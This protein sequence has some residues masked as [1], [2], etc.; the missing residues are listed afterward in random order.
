MAFCCLLR[1]PSFQKKSERSFYSL[2]K[3][4]KNSGLFACEEAGLSASSAHIWLIGAPPCGQEANPRVFSPLC[5]TAGTK[6][7]DASVP[8]LFLHCR[9]ECPA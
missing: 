1:Q 3:A 8:D 7:L 9:D 6:A 4:K 2:S 5:M